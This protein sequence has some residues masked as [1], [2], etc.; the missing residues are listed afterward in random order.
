[1]KKLSD[2]FKAL[3]W[4]VFIVATGAVIVVK[5]VE[6]L[7]KNRPDLIEQFEDKVAQLED[8]IP[9][10]ENA[11]AEMSE[12]LQ[13]KVADVRRSV[14]KDAR[15]AVKAV[16][17]GAKQVKS[18]VAELTERQEALLR[19]IQK[20]EQATMAAFKDEVKGVTE[21]TLRRDL[22]KLEAAKLITKHG[23]TKSAYYK[24]R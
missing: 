24:A 6:Y 1:M 18:A 2:T 15:T 23:S 14:T 9:Q 10:I 16:N 21:R 12:P 8:V 13:D 5:L 19:F 17:K 3:F 20:Y 4:F 22:A 7:K 11:V